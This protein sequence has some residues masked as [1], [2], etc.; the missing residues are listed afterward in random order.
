MGRQEPLTSQA[1]VTMPTL[2]SPSNLARGEAVPQPHE[3][4]Y[5]QIRQADVRSESW[6]LVGSGRVGVGKR[7]A[8]TPAPIARTL[9][10]TVHCEFESSTNCGPID[11][12]IAIGARN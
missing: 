10:Y 7:H 3:P 12:P 5:Y 1:Y 2:S 11:V 6:G 4:Y 8:T 9:V